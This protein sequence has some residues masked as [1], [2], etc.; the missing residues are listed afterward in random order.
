MKARCSKC[1]SLYNL[2]DTRIPDEGLQYK[3][4]RCGSIVFFKKGSPRIQEKRTVSVSD[5]TGTNPI[6]NGAY[7]GA[8]GGTGCAIPAV[9]M[10]MLGI[11]FMSLGMEFSG[12]SVA[13]SVLMSFLRMLSLGVLI[14]ITLAFIGAKTRTDIWSV[15]GG[16]IGA[17]MGVLIGLL[18]G[19]FIST[20]IGGI[21]GAI[22]IVG[23]VGIWIIQTT[24]IT[25]VVIL[26][27]KYTFFSD[28]ESSLSSDIS[29]IQKGA[30]GIL[31][32]LMFFTIVMEAKG[33]YLA[34]S[35]YDEVMKETSAEG[36]LVKDLEDIYN[37][38]GDLMITGSIE[39]TSEDDKTGWYLIAELFDEDENV[40]RKARLI[41]GEQLYSVK[42]HTILRERGERI[43][44]RDPFS[45]QEDMIIEPGYAVP[46]EVVFFDPPEEYQE[47]SVIL[48]N[49]DKS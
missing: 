20:I 32:C 30:I 38:E 10:S 3:C 41:N 28:E 44:R 34:K 15:R 17:L 4:P 48:K 22:A 26:V 49:L 8:L 37:E 27:R 21:F 40:L 43:P 5:D 24:I 36:F 23:T 39:N 1:K 35:G 16:L 11:G 33:L 7:A 2:D 42:D 12:F 31:F 19:I 25:I 14:G 46:F 18:Y 6:V 29:G 9:L 45:R 47:Y 13:A